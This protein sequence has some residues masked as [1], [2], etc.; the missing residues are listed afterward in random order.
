[1]VRLNEN[2]LKVKQIT[3]K[4]LVT[5]ILDWI[6]YQTDQ[7]LAWE[8]IEELGDGADIDCR[9]IVDIEQIIRY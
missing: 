7:S 5:D 4:S 6:D 3:K 2:G 1:M 9:G 8:I